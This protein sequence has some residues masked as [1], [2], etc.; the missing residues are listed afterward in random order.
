MNLKRCGRKQ[1]RIV[2]IDAKSRREGRALSEFGH[3]DTMNK[4]ETH[5]FY[6]AFANLLRIRS[7]T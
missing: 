5:L 6:G 2:A 4:D 3:Y 1:H 7:S